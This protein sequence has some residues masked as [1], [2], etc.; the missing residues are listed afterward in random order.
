M[1]RACTFTEADVYRALKAAR[2]AG[3]PVH[4]FEIDRTGKIVVL[5]GKAEDSA[6]DDNGRNE[7]DGV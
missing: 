3:L 5:T 1:S 2:K 6:N 4:K 7:W